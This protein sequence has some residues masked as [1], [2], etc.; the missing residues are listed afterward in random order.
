MRFKPRTD[1]ERI[2]EEISKNSF[3]STDY[4]Q[5]IQRQL[6]QLDLNVFHAKAN[7][8]NEDGMGELND[9]YY[10]SK[11]DYIVRPEKN[12]SEKKEIRQ[13][14]YKKPINID[15]KQI[16]PE[17]HFKTHF[18]GAESVSIATKINR[19]MSQRKNNVKPFSTF[20]DSNGI[21]LSSRHV[22]LQKRSGNNCR[23]L[24]DYTKNQNPNRVGKENEIGFK[25]K[26][27]Q[28]K[29]II[30]RGSSSLPNILKTRDNEQEENKYGRE[31]EIIHIG[32]KSYSIKTQFDI[33]TRKMLQKCNVYH[34]KNKNN[35]S[36]VKSRQGKLMITNGMTVQEF[37]AKY[38]F[39]LIH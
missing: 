6:T 15:A 33:I 24:M 16:M 4:N 7:Y 31:D 8:K 2:K 19:E 27:E 18:K 9:D 25:E 3:Q 39:S 23:S 20:D 30:H 5:I 22:S 28:L 37:E 38:N 26:I 17:F 1:L 34:H 32:N 10:C 12:T 35:N 36:F 13:I 11:E 14:K 29:E 21:S